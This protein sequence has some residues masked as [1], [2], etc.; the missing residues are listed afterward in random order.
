MQRVLPAAVEQQGCWGCGDICLSWFLFCM[1]P[2]QAGPLQGEA[3]QVVGR[4]AACAACGCGAEGVLGVW[5]RL[6]ELVLFDATPGWAP[7]GRSAL[8][9]GA[10]CIG[11]QPV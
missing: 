8:T 1:I 6:P 3:Q 5:G 4:G 2:P 9:G 10:G 11:L 7:A